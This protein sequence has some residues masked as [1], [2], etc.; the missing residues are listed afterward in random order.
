MVLWVSSIVGYITNKIKNVLKIFS[1]TLNKRVG[2]PSTELVLIGNSKTNRIA[3]VGDSGVGKSTFLN[4][5]RNTPYANPVQTIGYD[6]WVDK[7]MLNPYTKIPVFYW[8]SGSGRQTSELD[9]INGAF[10]YGTMSSMNTFILVYDVTWEESMI[11]NYIHRWIRALDRCPNAKSIIV[12]LRR[13]DQ[14]HAPIVVCSEIDDMIDPGIITTCICDMAS[15]DD[16][17]TVVHY[18]K[19]SCKNECFQNSFI[20]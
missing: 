19:I 14:K 11:R 13:P 18:I 4:C 15:P 17:K 7:S 12:G 20:T 1:F 5:L 3:I 16:C 9:F 2:K 8:D 10:P 6:F